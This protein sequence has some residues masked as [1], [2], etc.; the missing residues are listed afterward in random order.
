MAQVLIN[1]RS[2]TPVAVA[3]ALVVAAAVAYGVF[4]PSGETA[5]QG[6]PTSVDA[7]SQAS[8]APVSDG[9]QREATSEEKTEIESIKAQQAQASAA[10]ESQLTPEP[11]AAAPMT[12]PDYISD[13]EWTM[14]QGVAN[15]AKDPQAELTRLVN[16]LRFNKQLE[17]WQDL[18]ADADPGKRATLARALLDDLPERVKMGNFGLNDAKTMAEQMVKDVEPN[19]AKHAARLKKEHKRLEAADADYR[20]AGGT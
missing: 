14:L 12:R 7:P 9:F 8:Q 1:S 2:R 11:V 4:G 6:S 3:I 18:P 5:T 19:E 17:M 20:K 16:S 13:M 10:M 15:Q